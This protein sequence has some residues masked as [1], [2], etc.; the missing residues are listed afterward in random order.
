MQAIIIA[1]I[2]GVILLKVNKN[3]NNFSFLKCKKY[4][5]DYN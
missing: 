1:T 5:L 2:D 3:N 4:I